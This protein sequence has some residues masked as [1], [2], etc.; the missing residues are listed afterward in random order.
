MSVFKIFAVTFSV[1]PQLPTEGR[2]RVKYEG[3]NAILSWPKPTG[4]YTRQ[5]IEQWTTNKRKKR[6]TESECRKSETCKEHAVD[7]NKTTT[8]I[9]VSHHGYTF[10]LVLYDG[11]VPLSRYESH[12][13]RQGNYV[14]NLRIS[15]SL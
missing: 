5:V 13:E 10:I 7:K 3:N 2:L 9:H 1:K 6:S 12:T 11:T 15:N 8:T 4:D 14:G